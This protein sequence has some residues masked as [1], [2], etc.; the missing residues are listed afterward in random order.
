MRLLIL[1]LGKIFHFIAILKDIFLGGM[2]VHVEVQE[3]LLLIL[4]SDRL[5]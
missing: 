2:T 1:D 3:D 5:A 4:L